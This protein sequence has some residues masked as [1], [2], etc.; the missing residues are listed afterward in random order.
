MSQTLKTA[1][2]R[3]RAPKR[4]PVQEWAS[5]QRGNCLEVWSGGSFL[6]IAFVDDRA[7][8]GHLLWVIEN[9]TGSRR[10]FVRDDPITLYP[11]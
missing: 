5:L 6:Y 4:Q 1:G 2:G 9:G 10:L 3:R 11:I 8:D 7:E